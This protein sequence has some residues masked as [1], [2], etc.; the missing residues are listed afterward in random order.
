MYLRYVMY[1]NVPSCT[2]MS[3]SVRMYAC[4]CAWNCA[5]LCIETLR[6]RSGSYG[7]KPQGTGGL[8]TPNGCESLL[9]QLKHFHQYPYQGLQPHICRSIIH[10]AASRSEILHHRQRHKLQLWVMFPVI[11]PVVRRR[12][13]NQLGL[14]LGSV[15]VIQL[16]GVVFCFLARRQAPTKLCNEDPGICWQWCIWTTCFDPMCPTE[17]K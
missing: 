6:S 1:V 9:D 15:Q 13:P 16:V 17:K 3:C 5:H 12:W 10:D 11:R 2:V 7:V 14:F 4:G 8:A